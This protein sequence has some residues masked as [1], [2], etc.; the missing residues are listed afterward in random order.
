MTQSKQH[1]SQN[2]PASQP[3][4]ASI[5]PVAQRPVAPSEPVFV[6]TP[7]THDDISQRAYDIYVESGYQ[8]GQSSQNWARAEKDLKDRGAVA[9]RAEHRRK[10]VFAL[11]SADPR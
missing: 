8:Q 5:P 3:K 6:A 1:Q 10:G 4:N 7:P 11:D 2:H 9:W